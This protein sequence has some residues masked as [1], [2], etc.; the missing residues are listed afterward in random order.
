SGDARADFAAYLPDGD[1]ERF[2]DGL[3]KA[4]RERFSATMQV[5]RDPGFQELCLSYKRP[6]RQFLIAYG[7]RDTVRS[8]YLFRTGDGRELKPADYLA[9]FSRFVREHQADIDAIAV[10]LGRPRDWDTARLAELRQTLQRAPERFTEANLRRAYQAEL[11]DIISM[12]KHAARD[13]EPLLSAAERAARAVAAVSAG[14]ELS[15]E[16][17]AWLG[18]IERHLAA[19]LTI[20]PDDFETVPV[21]ADVGGWGRANRVFGG[22]LPALLQ[23]CN[24]AMAA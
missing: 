11:A 14:R 20:E 21:F 12:V 6:S 7:V 22:Q 8:E 15:E 2:A 16:Q 17:R 9:A 19:N 10:L 18:R 5:L 4:L 13:E 24:E 23:Q 3:P 1:V